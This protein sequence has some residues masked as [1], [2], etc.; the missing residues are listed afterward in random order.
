MRVIA[1]QRVRR[2]LD[3]AAQ[4]GSEA[5]MDFIYIGLGA[6]MFALFAL[7]AVLLRRV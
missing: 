1:A 2:S 5:S 7:Y 3:S 4:D 6:G